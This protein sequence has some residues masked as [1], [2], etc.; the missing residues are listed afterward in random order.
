[1]GGIE[2]AILSKASQII[3]M[4]VCDLH[5]YNAISSSTKLLA[6]LGDSNILKFGDPVFDRLKITIK[7]SLL[8]FIKNSS[9]MINCEFDPQI[10]GWIVIMTEGEFLAC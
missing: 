5:R 10:A 3:A 2:K 7:E 4:P 1:M 8:H 6:K 9:M